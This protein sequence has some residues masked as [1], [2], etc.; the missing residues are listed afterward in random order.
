MKDMFFGVSLLRW[1][2]MEVAGMKS[3][4]LMRILMEMPNCDEVIV[5]LLIVIDRGIGSMRGVR[6]C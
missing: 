2:L 4:C 5:F 3:G 6:L 1:F